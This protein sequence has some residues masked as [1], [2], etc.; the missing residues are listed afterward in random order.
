MTTCPKCDHE[1]LV[2]TAELG[3]IPLDVCPGCHGIWFDKGELEALL[4]QSQGD[5]PAGFDLISPKPDVLGC[6]RCRTKMSRGGLVN[7]LLLVDK[8]EACGGV[9]L[10]QRELALVQKLLGLSGGAEGVRVE[11]P[12]PAPAAPEEKGSPVLKY[13]LA[14]A[15][16]MGLVLVSYELYVYFSP[17]GSVEREFSAAMTAFGA[18]LLVGGV[19]GTLKFK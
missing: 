2:K 16:F 17:A 1:T 18:L 8:C 5:V 13:A 3:D 7:P 4:K 6:P 9:W 10:D 11:R 12:A 19:F 15:A 14:L